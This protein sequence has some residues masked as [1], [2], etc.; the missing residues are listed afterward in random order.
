MKGPGSKSLLIDSSGLNN[1][2]TGNVNLNF[3]S[4]RMNNEGLAF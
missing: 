2:L 3:P 1:H 4:W